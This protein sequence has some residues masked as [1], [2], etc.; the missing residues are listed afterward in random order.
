MDVQSGWTRQ[1][2]VAAPEEVEDTAQHLVEADST[3]AHEEEEVVVSRGV[4]DKTAV[5]R[6]EF[7][8]QSLL[9]LCFCGFV[10][11]FPGGGYSGDRGYGDRSYGDRSF[12]GERSFGSG[13]YRSGGGG[14]YS[15]GGGGGYRDNR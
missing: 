8:G 14:G 10:F 5:S 3:V 2:K 11:V 12:G 13:G 4:R 6:G 9:T 7:T 15:S 1:E